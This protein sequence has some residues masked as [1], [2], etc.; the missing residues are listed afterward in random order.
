[1]RVWL[2]KNMNQLLK[3]EANNPFK[4]LLIKMQ[5]SRA[6]SPKDLRILDTLKKGPV[7]EFLHFKNIIL[8]DFF[9]LIIKA[10]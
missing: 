8:R 10:F 2:K 3:T 5:F 9:L 7:W 4:Y 6:V 1:M